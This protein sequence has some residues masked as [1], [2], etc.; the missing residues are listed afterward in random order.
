MLFLQGACSFIAV[1]ILI[2]SNLCFKRKIAIFMLEV[3]AVIY[4][5]APIVHL[6]YDG[7]PGNLVRFFLLFSKSVDYLAPLFMLFSFNIY[8]RDLLS[9]KTEGV[10]RN[11]R[12]RSG[13]FFCV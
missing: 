12:I 5:G 6:T 9:H 1:L 8:L 3:S 7:V 2:T 11:R 4:L 13:F 10:K